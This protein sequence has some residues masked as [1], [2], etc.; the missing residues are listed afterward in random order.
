MG[1]IQLSAQGQFTSYLTA[2]KLK[3]FPHLAESSSESEEEEEVNMESD[4]PKL[5]DEELFADGGIID[6]SIFI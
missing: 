1:P 3:R 5:S 6:K 4:E 2:N